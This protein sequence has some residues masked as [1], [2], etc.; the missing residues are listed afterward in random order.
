ML[1]SASK[2]EIPLLINLRNNVIYIV[3]SS[4]ASGQVFSL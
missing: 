1:L 3:V 2:S 4:V